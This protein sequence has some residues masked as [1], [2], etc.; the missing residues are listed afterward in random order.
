[1]SIMSIYYAR[2]QKSFE[3]THSILRFWDLRQLDSYVF[4]RH[5][6]LSCESMRFVYHEIYLQFGLTKKNYGNGCLCDSLWKTDIYCYFFETYVHKSIIHIAQNANA[7]WHF[8]KI[9]KSASMHWVCECCVYDIRTSLELSYRCMHVC[10]RA[11]VQVYW[12]RCFFGYTM[13]FVHYFAWFSCDKND[14]SCEV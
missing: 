11:C 13:S 10:M 5:T 9:Q 14:M 4:V 7:I 6:L 8:N 1:M 12:L 3:Y 2:C